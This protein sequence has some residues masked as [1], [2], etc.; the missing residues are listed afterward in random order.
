[1]SATLNDLQSIALTIEADDAVGSAVPLPAG[2]AV[3]FTVDDTTVLALTA[4]AD[5]V[6]ASGKGLKA[7][8]AN[9]SAVLT[10]TPA[11]S[12]TPVS[13]SSMAVAINVIASTIVS[14][15]VITGAVA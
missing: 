2:A 1:M 5:G 7:G 14:I 6:S 12:T 4:G 11:G 3:R 8:V 10:F 13:F 9:V 15:K